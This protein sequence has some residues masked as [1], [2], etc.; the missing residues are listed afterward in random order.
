MRVFE[1]RTAV[2][3]GGGTGVGAAVAL[4]LAKAGASV[5]L[6]GRRLDKLQTTAA[7]ARN[8]GSHAVCYIGDLAAD[9]SQL[10]L[11]QRLIRDLPHI[12]ILIQ[13]AATFPDRI[14]DGLFGRA[15]ERL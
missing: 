1:N 5:H 2:I 15:C 4:A 7:K 9:S 10:E 13:N 6:I 14:A 11:T 8:L 12:D 3:T